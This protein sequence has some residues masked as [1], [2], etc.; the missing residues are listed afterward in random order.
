MGDPDIRPYEPAAAPQVLALW[1]RALGDRYSLREEVLR[2]TLERD[3]EHRPGDALVAWDGGL[4]VG[5]GYVG[6]VR[7]ADPETAAHRGRA[8]LQAVVVDPGRRRRG[9]GRSLVRRLAEVADEQG[10]TQIDCGGGFFYLWPGLPADLPDARPFAEA[11][12]FT[13]H[14]RIWDLRGEVAGLTGDAEAAAIVA[15]AGLAIGAA[16]DADRGALL[17]FIRDEF[18]GEWWHDIRWF[19][20]EGG[21]PADLVLLRDA[22]ALATGAAPIA[23]FARIHTPASRPIGW[24]MYWADLRPPAAGGLGPIGVASAVRGRGLG[25]ALLTL[26]LARL[27]DAGLTDVVIDGTTLLGFYGQLGFA[28]WM[29]FLE[30]RATVRDVLD[31]ARRSDSGLGYGG[32]V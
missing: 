9:L 20:D 21:D 12:G 19:L 5:F 24:P 22:G 18:G 1:S 30:A 11:L 25:R 7:G 3:P 13:V 14:D 32:G 8:W 6:I 23:G 15:A 10:I 29:E 4:A 16:R 26:S 17:A 2:A 27:R 31:R 28:P